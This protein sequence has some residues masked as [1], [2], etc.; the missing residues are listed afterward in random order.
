LKKP[1]VAIIVP[2]YNEEDVVEETAQKLAHVLNELVEH[3]KISKDSFLLFVEDASLDTTW[4]IIRRIARNVKTIRAIRLSRRFGH[5]NSLMAGFMYARG[6]SDCVISIDADLQQ[7]ENKIPAFIEKFSQGF[8]VIHGIR[9]NRDADSFLKKFS[10]LLFYHFLNLMGVKI[11]KNSADYRLIS[12]R[13]LDELSHFKEVN[14]YLRGLF[15]I[16]G[17]KT[18][19]VI[20]DVSRRKA[21]KSKYSIRKMILLALDAVTSFSIL[22]IRLITLLGF[23]VFLLS[24]VMIMYVVYMSLTYKTVTGWASTVLPIYFLGGIQLLA[25]GLVGEYVGKSYMETKRRPR[26]IVSEVLE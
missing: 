26:Y 19:Y 6:K 23:I 15:P 7:D 20:H 14:L 2:C 18:A 21:G 22:P 3:S 9:S 4:D 24:C 10:V 17:F 16:L 25:I 1:K 13:V 5:Q 8:E 11:V 12:S